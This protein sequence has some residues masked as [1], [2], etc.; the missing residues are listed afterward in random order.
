[1][2]LRVATILTIA[3]LITL[4]SAEDSR[5]GPLQLYLSWS[6]TT[7]QDSLVVA[8]RGW[9]HCYL[10]VNPAEARDG[11]FGY[12]GT[13]FETGAVSVQRWRYLGAGATEDFEL[14]MIEGEQPIAY[15]EAECDYLGQ[16]TALFEFDVYV[17]AELLAEVGSRTAQIRL[18]P[19]GSSDWDP[20]VFYRVNPGDPCG[21]LSQGFAAETN[22]ITAVAAA[23]PI[24]RSSFGSLKALYR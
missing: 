10:W 16:P 4:T 14:A 24:R 13:L 20:M 6:S 12:W 19:L 22:V 3:L 2:K 18:F 7:Q 21:L 9:T 5:G 23:V 17:D 15:L 11:F 8:E 1:M